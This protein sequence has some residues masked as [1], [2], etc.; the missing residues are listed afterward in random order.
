MF[1][2]IFS[3]YLN[4]D[5]FNIDLKEIKKEIFKLKKDDPK[6][7]IITN[8]GGWQSQSYRE[9]KKPLEKLFNEINKSILTVQEKLNLNN[10]LTLT[11]YWINI[12]YLGSFNKPHHH[13]KSMVSGV[14]YIN[15]PKKSG[16]IIFTQP[17]TVFPT[18][19]NIDIKQHNEYNSDYWT[20]KPE[21]NK[22]ILFPSYLQHY[23]ESNLNKEERI[24]ISFN[25]EF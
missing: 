3:S 12:N 18:E 4:I 16:N 10:N 7:K 6:G 5:F 1:N 13:D 17:Y 15:T 21:K 19:K 8:N 23:V 24:S 25:Y 22:C 14:Y 2:S 11:N 9:I 20:V